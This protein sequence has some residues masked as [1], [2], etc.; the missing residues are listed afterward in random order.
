MFRKILENLGIVERKRRPGVVL[1]SDNQQRHRE[2]VQGW[3]E[4]LSVKVEQRSDSSIPVLGRPNDLF[5]SDLAASRQYTMDRRN[6]RRGI[7]GHGGLGA[8]PECPGGARRFRG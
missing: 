6:P 8:D 2:E 3:L 4:R 5:D 1:P 7:E